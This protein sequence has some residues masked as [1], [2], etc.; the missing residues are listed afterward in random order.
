METEAAVETNADFRFPRLNKSKESLPGQFA[1]SPTGKP[2]FAQHGDGDRK[3]RSKER[4]REINLHL[5]MSHRRS[6][7]VQCNSA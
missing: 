4:G 5:A 1:V 7:P 2:P 3:D 6:R